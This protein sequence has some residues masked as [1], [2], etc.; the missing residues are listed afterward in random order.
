MNV[1]GVTPA[2]T[3]DITRRLREWRSGKRE[4]GDEVM[5]MLYPELRRLAA[6]FMRMERPGHTLQPTAL[7][8]ELYIKL[9]SGARVDWQ[10]RAHFLAYAAQKLRHILVDHAR[11][12][13]MAEHKLREVRIAL[14]EEDGW[15]GRDDASI[16]ALEEALR[17]LEKVD[18]RA[19]RVLE[20]RFFAGLTEA[21]VAEHLGIAISTVKRDFLFARVWLFRHLTTHPKQK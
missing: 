11:R 17:R 20:L 8:H 5:S 7:V 3:Q 9:M 6:H 21:E 16:V 18:N 15:T 1:K 10:D 19:Y 2:D 12:A 14:R 4:A 13:R